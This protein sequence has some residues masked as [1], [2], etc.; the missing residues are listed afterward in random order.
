[1][2]IWKLADFELEQLSKKFEKHVVRQ[3]E[4]GNISKD[5]YCRRA[6]AHMM[7]DS[8]ET[9]VSKSGYVLRYNPHTKEF[10]AAK[11]SGIIETFFIPE[12]ATEYWNKQIA[13]YGKE[14]LVK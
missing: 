11:P 9:I 3:A 6:I 14:R 1:M 10:G 5:E 13:M 4:F 2:S 8:N 7:D 12:N